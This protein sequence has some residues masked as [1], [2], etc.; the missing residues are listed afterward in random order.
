MSNTDSPTALDLQ[1]VD[2]LPEATQKYFDICQDKLGMV[3]NVLKAYAFNNEKLE[4]FVEMLKPF[5]I[6]EL[7]RTGVIAMPRGNTADNGRRAIRGGI[8]RYADDTDGDDLTDGEEVNT[9]NTLPLDAD[10]DD[11]GLSD[12]DEVNTGRIRHKSWIS[13]I[14]LPYICRIWTGSV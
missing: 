3:P 8:V 12:G 2:P 6:I 10:S 4:A 5:G 11:D 1:M 14:I 13:R 9:T 7:A